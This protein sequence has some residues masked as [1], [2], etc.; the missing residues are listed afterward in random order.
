[1][2][3]SSLPFFL[4]RSFPPWYVFLILSVEHISPS[5]LPLYI[6]KGMGNHNCYAFSTPSKVNNSLVSSTTQPIFKR[7]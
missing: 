2:F 4:P 3:P 7:P 1:M 5:T 6:G